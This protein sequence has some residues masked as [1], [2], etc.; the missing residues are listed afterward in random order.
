MARRPKVNYWPS[1][2]GY[3]CWFN[4]KQRILADGP[5]D[6]PD[7]PTYQKALREFIGLTA[8]ANADAAGDGN[9]MQTLAELYLRH[10][11]GTK[12][13]ATYRIRR[14]HLQPLVDVMGRTPV[15]QLTR[16]MVD[17]FLDGMRQWRT[18][19][20]TGHRVR[21][22][23]GSVRNAVQSIQ[24]LL[25]WSVESGLISRNPLGAMP[26]P[27]PSSRGRLALLGATPEE[28][29]ETHRRILGASTKAFRPLLVCLEATG[30]RPG[31]LI[32]ATAGD[33]DAAAGA[34]IYH[35]DDNRF[36]GEFRHKTAGHGKDRVILLSGEA[37]EV[38]RN[39]K[40]KHSTGPLFRT[41]CGKRW[42]LNEVM[43]R[44]RLL[45]RKLGIKNLTAYSYRHTFAT[46]WLERGGSIDVL[47]ELLGNTAE[48]IRKHY[49]HLLVNR[50]NLRRQ[51]EAYR[52]APAVG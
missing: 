4:G 46:G 9:D 15:R 40:Q 37:L 43:R 32:H 29:Q 20:S 21:W 33:F 44:F 5:D 25:N 7:G 38:V 47:A 10:V 18:S 8:L 48:V 16:H 35:A 2:G 31:E 27:R 49:S 13:A 19:P 30:A 1:R 24:A 3:G 45:R 34:I 36:D 14:R 52:A 26:A 41:R 23:N 51:L 50:Q 17:C 39:L 28:R 6:F 42:R 12:S 11:H 22:E